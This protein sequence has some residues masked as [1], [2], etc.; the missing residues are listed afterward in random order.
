MFDMLVGSPVLHERLMKPPPMSTFEN[1]GLLFRE[2]LQSCSASI[3]GGA[4]ALSQ[5]MRDAAGGCVA[6]SKR[7]SLSRHEL[8]HE[9]IAVYFRTKAS[10]NRHQREPISVP[11]VKLH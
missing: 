3:F 9:L 4:F 11:P 2:H 1:Y 5:N 10:M 6:K 7:Y 8:F